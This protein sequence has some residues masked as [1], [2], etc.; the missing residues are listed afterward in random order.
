MNF[1]SGFMS[2]VN[3]SAVVKASSSAQSAVIFF[4][5]P[6]ERWRIVSLVISLSS[7]IQRG[8]SA[9]T[10]RSRITAANRIQLRNE[11]P[12]GTFRRRLVL[13]S[14]DTA[15]ALFSL[16]GKAEWWHPM[17]LVKTDWSPHVRL[18]MRPPSPTVFL[19][20]SIAAGTRQPS[21]SR[22]LRIPS[23][24]GKRRQLR[25]QRKITREGW[26]RRTEWTPLA[27]RQKEVRN[28]CRSAQWKSSAIVLCLSLFSS[29]LQ[30]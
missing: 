7:S 26:H 13:R 24:R 8:Q 18:E 11:K 4:F 9:Q 19:L 22:L 5:I 21:S 10:S 15:W 29:V 2:S 16:L 20:L 17:L 25:W 30:N 14:F 28:R 12:E 6:P 27:T 3:H 1:W 23:T